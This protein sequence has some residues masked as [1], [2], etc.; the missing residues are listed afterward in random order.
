M[1][2]FDLIIVG[3]VVYFIYSRFASGNLPK[4]GQE[5]KKN[6]VEIKVIKG[7]AQ[8]REQIEKIFKK[9]REMSDMEMKPKQ[10]IDDL[11]GLEKLKA[12]D[13][14]FTEKKFLTGAKKAYQWVYDFINNDDEQALSEMV[15]PKIYARFVELLNEH[16]AKGESITIETKISGNPKVLQYKTVAK[17]AFIEVQYDVEEKRIV[18]VK[19]SDKIVTE[20]ESKISTVW[21]WARNMSST[22]PN[23]QLEGIQDA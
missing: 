5:K 19:E 8:T 1:N 17:T 11:E 10:N 22:D 16:D 12:Y 23:W 20:T 15:S 14:D 18:K 7:N 13:P 9:A 2:I 6:S 4:P 3:V 21:T